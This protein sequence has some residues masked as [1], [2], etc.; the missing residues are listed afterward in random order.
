MAS[1]TP[2][3]AEHSF[4]RLKPSAEDYDTFM[5]LAELR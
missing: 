2:A 1:L 4:H 5:T 3:L